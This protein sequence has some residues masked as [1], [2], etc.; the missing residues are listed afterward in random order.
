MR[1]SRSAPVGDISA[2]AGPYRRPIQPPTL[3]TRTSTRLRT[4]AGTQNPGT[5]VPGATTPLPG[6]R[7]GT[8]APSNHAV[9]LFTRVYQFSILTVVTGCYY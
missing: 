5:T 1:A 4:T 8:T 7:S 3:W 2:A 6:T 9:C